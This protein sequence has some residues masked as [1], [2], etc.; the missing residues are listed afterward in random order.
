MKI[1]HNDKNASYGTAE[2]IGGFDYAEKNILR[3]RSK[4]DI[5]YTNRV[6]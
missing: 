6:R 1:S 2:T 3:F 4:S 5:I